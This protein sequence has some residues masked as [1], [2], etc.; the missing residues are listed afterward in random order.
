MSYELFEAFRNDEQVSPNDIVVLKKGFNRKTGTQYIKATTV[1]GKTYIKEFTNEGVE[2]TK[3]LSIPHY[4]TK[5]QRDKLI[6]EL[7]E[8]NYTQVEISDMLGISQ[9]TVHNVLKKGEKL[10]I[11]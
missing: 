11:G 10:K 4:E 6:K 1:S 9:S 5:K 7:R 2:I 3:N 8:N